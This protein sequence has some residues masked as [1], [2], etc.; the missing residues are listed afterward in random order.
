MIKISDAL[1]TQ[2]LPDALAEQPEIKAFA[3]ALRKQ[4]RTLAA[5]MEGIRIY[6]SVDTASEAV[7]DILAV[8]LLIT[9]YSQSYSITVK[10]N[11]IKNALVNWIKNGTVSQLQSVVDNIFGA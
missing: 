10:R 1:I 7:L 4:L 8:D 6:S 11:L 3:Q 2:A 5:A 9:S